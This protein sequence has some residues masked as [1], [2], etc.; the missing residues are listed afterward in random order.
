MVVIVKANLRKNVSLY[1]ILLNFVA[2]RGKTI[3]TTLH[4]PSS[5]LFSMFDK[6]LLIA[7]GRV[8]FLGNSEEAYEFFKTYV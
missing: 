6:I 2:A 4:Q 8:A 3:I 7:E 5:E 1:K